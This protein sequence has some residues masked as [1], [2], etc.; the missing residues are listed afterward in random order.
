MGK[1]KGTSGA[2]MSGLLQQLKD[3]DEEIQQLRQTVS[4]TRQQQ[5]SRTSHNHSQ[6]AS[7]TPSKKISL[8][9]TESLQ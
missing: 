2:E 8:I 4:R 7:L 9:R 3:K 1:E 5:S 6:N